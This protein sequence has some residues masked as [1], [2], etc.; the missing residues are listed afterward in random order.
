[1]PDDTTAWIRNL[2]QQVVPDDLSEADLEEDLRDYGLDS[3]RL[4]DVLTAL[5]E[6][7]HPVELEELAGEPTLARLVAVVSRATA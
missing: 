2:A 7:G 4:M 3:V 5:R 6:Q 1:M